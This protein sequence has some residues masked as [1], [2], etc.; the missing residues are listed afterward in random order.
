MK[1]EH[2]IRELHGS[3]NGTAKLVE[4]EAKELLEDYCKKKKWIFNHRRKEKVSFA[5][6]LETGIY[7]S[8]RNID[9]FFACEIVVSSLQEIEAVKKYISDI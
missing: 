6:K 7:C 3:L 4:N 1:V 2:S 8:I 5:Q 9:D